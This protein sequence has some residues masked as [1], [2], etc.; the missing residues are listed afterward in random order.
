VESLNL[1]TEYFASRRMDASVKRALA[2]KK[3]N[4]LEI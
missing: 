1:A 2:G 3:L 4:T